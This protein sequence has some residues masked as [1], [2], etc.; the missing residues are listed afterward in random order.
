MAARR[1]NDYPIFNRSI[2]KPRISNQEEIE[3]ARIIQSAP[4]SEAAR[5]ARNRMVQANMGLLVATAR[6]LHYVNR[7]L[8]D[9]I[10]D[11]S[12][13]L[14]RA[15]EKFNPEKGVRFST[16]A[17][18]WIRQAMRLGSIADGD[19]IRLPEHIHLKIRRIDLAQKSLLQQLK[20]ITLVDLAK[21]A[22]LEI[23]E[24]TRL[25]SLKH[26]TLSFDEPIWQ[27]TGVLGEKISDNGAWMAQ[28]EQSIL[29]VQLAEAIESL[30]P[31]Q[32][33]VLSRLYEGNLSQVE[34]AAE[35]GLNPATV[36]GYRNRGITNLKT[37]LT[38]NI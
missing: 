16:Y 20:P 30:P 25:L 1:S 35:L 6:K 36:R 33:S 32:R 3:L 11:G 29:A 23:A 12:L 26:R 5:I 24:V 37:K 27:G 31:N 19:T 17:Y 22:G 18:R 14:I 8:V 2:R 9:R 4:D 10:Q 38:L 7:P 15:A 34:I 28:H 21:E 13:G